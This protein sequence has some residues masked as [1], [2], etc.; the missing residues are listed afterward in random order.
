M[1]RAILEESIRFV[2]NINL[3]YRVAWMDGQI[4]DGGRYDDRESLHVVSSRMVVD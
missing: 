2:V 3:D 1:I 4:V